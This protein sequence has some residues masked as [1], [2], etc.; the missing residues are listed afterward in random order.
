MKP[1]L[2]IQPIDYNNKESINEVIIISEVGPAIFI[3][4]PKDG[5]CI[6]SGIKITCQGEKWEEQ[7]Q[8]LLLKISL[9]LI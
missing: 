8:V 2:K 5:N 9:F 6:I 4:I 7:S 1:D 3:D